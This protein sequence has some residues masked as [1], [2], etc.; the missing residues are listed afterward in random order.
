MDFDKILFM[1]GYYIIHVVTNTHSFKN[2]SNSYDPRLIL[3]LFLSSIS[4]EII[5]GFDTIW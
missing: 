5:G 3:E 1:H 2:F 4:C